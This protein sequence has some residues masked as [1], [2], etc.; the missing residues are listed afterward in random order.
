MSVDRRAL[1]LYCMY[2]CTVQGTE[3]ILTNSIEELGYFINVLTSVL[4][5][6]TSNDQELSLNIER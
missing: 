1:H 3:G 2:V 6:Q 5:L 4:T